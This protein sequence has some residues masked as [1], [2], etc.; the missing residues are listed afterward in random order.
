MAPLDVAVAHG[1]LEVQA[2]SGG[3]ALALEETQL[4]GFD[5]VEHRLAGGEIGA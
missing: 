5:R 4:G 2:A 1:R 3:L